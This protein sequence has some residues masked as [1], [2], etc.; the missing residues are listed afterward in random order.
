VSKIAEVRYSE[1]RYLSQYDLYVDLFER[2][3]LKV[4]D[5]VPVRNV[6]ILFSD[7]GKK[8]LKKVNYSTDEL[9]FIYEAINYIKRSFSRVMDFTK[10]VDGD[11]Y[12]VWKGELYCIFDLVEGRECE[13]A[14]PIDVATAARGLAQFHSSSEGFRGSLKEKHLVGKS[15]DTFERKYE[16]MIFFK[17]LANF[18]EIKTD[19]DTLFLA[20]VDGYLKEMKKSIEALKASSY[21][22]LCSEE[23]K[24]VLCHHDLAHHNIIINEDEAHFIDFDYSVIDLKVHDLC[25]FI[26][27][28]IKNQAYDFKKAIDIINEYCKYNS[29]HKKEKEVLNC[30]MKFPEDF[31]S[32]S[33]DYYSRRKDWEEEVFLDRLQKKINFKEDREEFLKL[34]EN[35]IS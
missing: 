17:N 32:A 20:N 14:N 15:I 11:V 7:K 2:F 31:Y 33:K 25:N 1:K 27:K 13:F 23:D 24:V 30:L 22:K 19:F 28:A 16:E 21:L 9:K 5:I 3:S 34:F 18:H 35:E 12:T 6:F 10:T 29:L 4:T 8:I 26:I